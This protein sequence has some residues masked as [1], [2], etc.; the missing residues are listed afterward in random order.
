MGLAV[1]TESDQKVLTGIYRTAVIKKHFGEHYLAYEKN[2]DRW[3][4]PLTSTK[5]SY[6]TIAVQKGDTTL[7]AC[8]GEELWDL[9]FISTYASI[10]TGTAVAT[11]L[12]SNPLACD[13]TINCTYKF[14]SHTIT[15]S[16]TLTAGTNGKQSATVLTNGWWGEACIGCSIDSVS[17]G[18]SKA[19]RVSP[20]SESVGARNALLTETAMSYVYIDGLDGSDR[21]QLD[22]SDISFSSSTT[23]YTSGNYKKYIKTL[24]FS[25][26][27]TPISYSTNAGAFSIDVDYNTGGGEFTVTKQGSWSK[28]NI[29]TPYD[30]SAS[31][32]FKYTGGSSSANVTVIITIKDSYYGNSIR[33]TYTLAPTWQESTGGE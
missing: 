6:K 18:L 22:F 12:L 24:T 20:T 14:S 13:V 8:S 2:G 10:S 1:Y 17:F 33:K 27:A 29:S 4:V 9:A 23:S 31:I 30:H 32:Q 28:D 7:Y 26:R 3:A 15:E 5:P 25:F 16:W 11:V 19:Y 21:I